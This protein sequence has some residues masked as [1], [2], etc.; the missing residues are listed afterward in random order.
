MIT[1][2][3]QPHDVGLDEAA[4]MLAELGVLAEDSRKILKEQLSFQ[5]IDDHL[6]W[7]KMLA[8]ALGQ[9]ADVARAHINTDNEHGTKH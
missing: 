8:F 3:K 1:G 9:L 4:D 5:N 2:S 7:L 6:R